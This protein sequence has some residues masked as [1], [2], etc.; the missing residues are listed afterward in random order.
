MALTMGSDKPKYFVLFVLG[1][2]G[3]YSAV[4]LYLSLS[5]CRQSRCL[6]QHSGYKLY[7]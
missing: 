3:I 4:S 2:V 5:R 7:P 6:K 1:F